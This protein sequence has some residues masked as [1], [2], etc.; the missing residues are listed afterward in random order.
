MLAI[1]DKLLP[2]AQRNG[3]FF[4]CQNRDPIYLKILTPPLHTCIR[5]DDKIVVYPYMHKIISS[6]YHVINIRR[7]RYALHPWPHTCMIGKLALEKRDDTGGT[8]GSWKVV[9]A[10]DQWPDPIHTSRKLSSPS[11]KRMIKQLCISWMPHKGKWL[12]E[13]WMRPYVY[14]RH[15]VKFHGGEGG[16]FLINLSLDLTQATS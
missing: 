4:F 5:W 15:M 8:R 14:M 13:K 12:S 9:H 7:L 11:P 16:S 3:P 2:G 10:C 1:I 6:Y